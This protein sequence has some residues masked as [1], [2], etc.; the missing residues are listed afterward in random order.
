MSFLFTAQKIFSGEIKN[1]LLM[2]L[3]K[4]SD[5]YQG[6]YD[7]ANSIAKVRKAFVALLV[8]KLSMLVD[9]AFL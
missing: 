8:V 3:S 7:I 1:H 5:A 9:R 4:K 6:Q 2:F